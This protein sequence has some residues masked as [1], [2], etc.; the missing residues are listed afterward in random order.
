[1]DNTV[2][3]TREF[4][5]E[6]AGGF[7]S[8]YS[9]RNT[10]LNRLI[11]RMFRKSME[12]RYR[13]TLEGC[14]PIEGKRVLDLGCGPG[15]YGIAL[16]R[17][18]AGE[19]LGIDFAEGMIELA[20]QQAQAAGV[21][22][23]CTFVVRDFFSYTPEVPFD[24]VVVMGVMDYIADP[25]PFVEKVLSMTGGRAFFS[26]PADGGLLAWQRQLRY[27]SRCPLYLYKRSQVEALFSGIPGVKVEQIERDFFVQVSPR[28]GD[29]H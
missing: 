2:V 25:K 8:I 26:F 9:N 10:A 17:A 5:H 24:Y 14:R 20:R 21:G 22:D 4:F 12:L 18:G 11:N 29:S 6:Y 15:H 3:R 27:R 28:A 16:A 13:K 19:V 23:R 1:M 7:N